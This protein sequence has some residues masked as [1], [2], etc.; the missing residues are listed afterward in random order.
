MN[1]GPE[2]PGRRAGVIRSETAADRWVNPG[3]YG[4]GDPVRFARALQLQ[5]ELLGL[6]P[7]GAGIAPERA[8]GRDDPV[9]R[10]DNRQRV[11]AACP[12]H[13]AP[14]RTDDPGDFAIAPSPTRQTVRSCTVPARRDGQLERPLLACEIGRKL[15][16]GP[17]KNFRR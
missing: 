16:G 12:A 4:E 5:Q 10:H 11:A 14:A 1:G 7:A 6:Q 17:V 9:A 8:A 3:A 2:R 15:F 13:R